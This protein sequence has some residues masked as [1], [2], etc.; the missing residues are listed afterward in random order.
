M[1]AGVTENAAKQAKEAS[2]IMNQLGESAQEIGEIIGIIQTLAS[3]T[4]LLSL[5]AAIE[6]AGAG[7]GGGRVFFGVSD[8]Y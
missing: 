1:G 6:A 3:Q 4:H 8:V 5:N 7:G 2:V